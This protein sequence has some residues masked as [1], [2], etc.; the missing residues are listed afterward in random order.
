MPISLRK[1]K[2][3]SPRKPRSPGKTKF[4]RD[5]HRALKTLTKAYKS[6]KR[7]RGRSRHPPL[8]AAVTSPPRL[9]PT[10]SAPPVSLTSPNTLRLFKETYPEMFQASGR[11]RHKSKRHGRARTHRRKRRQGSRTRRR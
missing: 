7:H 1:T 8:P 11:R 2:T 3:R 5:E 4:T 9:H 6:L 10:P